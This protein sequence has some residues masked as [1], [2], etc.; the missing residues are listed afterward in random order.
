MVPVSFLFI[1]AATMQL[2]DD[3]WE[4]ENMEK[5][6]FLRESDDS[7]RQ[8]KLS[9]HNISDSI[10]SKSVILFCVLATIFVDNKA[11]LFPSRE[12]LCK[13]ILLIQD[14]FAKLGMEIHIGTKK[15]NKSTK[16]IK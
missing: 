15:L 8:G 11:A 7:Y 3:I 1:T 2:L 4:R 13:G 16:E 14:I 6:K 5:V 10:A 12:Q 9:C